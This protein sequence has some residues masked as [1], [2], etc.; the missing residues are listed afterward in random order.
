MVVIVVVILAVIVVVNDGCE[1]GGGPS[2]GQKDYGKYI[3]V[4]IF[5]M[6]VQ[7]FRQD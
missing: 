2:K 7:R 4:H 1:V 3:G 6:F 5:F